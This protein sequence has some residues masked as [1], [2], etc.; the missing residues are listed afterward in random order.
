MQAISEEIRAQVIAELIAGSA[1][2]VTARKYK[3]SP[4]TVSR[5]KN[6]IAPER[7]KHIET[8]KRVRIDDLLLES[9]ANHLGALDRIAGYVSTP[10]YLKTQSAEG[11]A[12][13]YKEIAVTPLSILEAA[14]L[15]GEDASADQAAE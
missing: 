11:V 8:E 14:S 6:E 1:V 9:V 10:E 3:L 5:L 13:L 12:T 15:A 2:N 7:L 4:A